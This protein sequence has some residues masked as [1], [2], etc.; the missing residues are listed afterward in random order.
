MVGCSKLSVCVKERASGVTKNKDE[1]P[2]ASPSFQFPLDGPKSQVTAHS[3][4]YH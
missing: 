4:N 1:M 3:L 2:A